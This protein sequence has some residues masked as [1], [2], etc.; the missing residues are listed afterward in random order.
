M[1][2][3]QKFY[4]WGIFCLFL[5]TERVRYSHR[6]VS[7]EI[8]VDALEI[9]KQ[10]RYLLLLASWNWK[11]LGI[12]RGIFI[13]IFCIYLWTFAQST[14]YVLN[15]HLTFGDYQRHNSSWEE[16][17]CLQNHNIYTFKF[18]VH[19]NY[20][21]KYE[22]WTSGE[23]KYYANKQTLYHQLVHCEGLSVASVLHMTTYEDNLEMC[24]CL[25]TMSVSGSALYSRIQN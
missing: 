21:A 22:Q 24:C 12:E 5:H 10:S 16:I 1:H 15:L 17:F 6:P 7:P 18:T 20:Q 8:V 14:H 4:C 3:Y 13:C 9:M 11:V 23:L 19:V 2:K 25:Q